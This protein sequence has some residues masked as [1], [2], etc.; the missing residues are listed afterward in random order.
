MCWH[1]GMLC[2]QMGM[3]HVAHWD[4]IDTLACCVGTLACGTL[5]CCMWY[6]DIVLTHWHV[7]CGTVVLYWHTSMLC[8]HTGMGHA[9][10]LY[11]VHWYCTDTLAC[12][13][14]SLA[15]CIRFLALLYAV[16][17]QS[18]RKMLQAHFF[19]LNVPFPV[20]YKWL[21]GSVHKKALFQL[22]QHGCIPDK[23]L[24]SNVSWQTDFCY[25]LVLWTKPTA[26]H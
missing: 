16:R 11:V 7:V 13:V 25:T 19:P 8:W 23:P 21:S 24:H 26:Q 2:W 1:T 20:I 10:M 15:C 5:A 3:L 9:G 4:C 17:W 22:N 6:T 12:C 14:G 18:Y